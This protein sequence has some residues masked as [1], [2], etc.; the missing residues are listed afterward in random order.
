M[1]EFG[2]LDFNAEKSFQFI[3]LFGEFLRR[4]KNK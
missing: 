4:L 3:D 1:V 2:Y